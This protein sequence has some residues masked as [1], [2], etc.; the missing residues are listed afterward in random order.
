MRDRKDVDPKHVGVIGYG[1]GGGIAT[2]IAKRARENVTV[3]VSYYGGLKNIQT[4]NMVGKKPAVLYFHPKNDNYSFDNEIKAFETVMANNKT[5]VKVVN[6]EGAQYGF[7][8]Q[9][10]ESYGG[11]TGNTFMFYNKKSAD[12][13]WTILL[14]FL[15]THI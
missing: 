13:A 12:E 2:N 5:E 9:G 14:D 6:L 11:D 7:V 8:H 10:I 3:A 1:Y 15:K 4:I